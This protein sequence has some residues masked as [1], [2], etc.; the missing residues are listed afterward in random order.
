M[1]NLH[2]HT[3][4][5]LDG[6]LNINEVLK[7]CEENNLKYISITDHNTTEAYQEITNNNYTG[8]IINGIELDALIG[9]ETYDILC[10]N[11]ELN[12]VSEWAKKQY[13]TIEERQTKIF[14]E[15]KRICKDKNISLDETIPFNPKEEYAHGAIYRMLDNSFKE[16]YNFTKI[17]DLYREST[18]NEEFPL[19][20]DMSIVWPTIEEINNII[21]KNNGLI[22]L[23]HPYKYGKKDIKELLDKTLPYIDGIEIYNENT[24]EETDFLYKYAKDNNLLVSCGTDF[25]GN[26]HHKDLKTNIDKQIQQEILD[27]IKM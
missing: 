18:M 25:H 1:I 26:E 22:F 4:K 13:T 3:N 8:T 16:K 2:I 27:W 21:H 5:S 11:F 17:G 9:K 14:N 23:A 7:L 19:Y 20:L 10:Y 12:N 15:L 6:K 24:K